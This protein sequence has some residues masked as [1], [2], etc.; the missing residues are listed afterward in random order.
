M[1]GRKSRKSRRAVTEANEVAKHASMLTGTAKTQLLA[2]TSVPLPKRRYG[3]AKQRK[4]SMLQRTAAH[5]CNYW[6]QTAPTFRIPGVKIEQ[7]AER[8]KP[9]KADKSHATKVMDEMADWESDA[10]SAKKRRQTNAVKLAFDGIPP[11]IAE[12]ALYASQVLHHFLRPHKSKKDGRH[13]FADFLMRYK[14]EGEVEADEDKGKDLD[15]RDKDEDEDQ[16]DEDQDQGADEDWEDAPTKFSHAGLEYE[17]A[18]E[19]ENSECTGV[20]HL[21]H[22]WQ[23]QGHH[24]KAQMELTAPKVEESPLKPSADMFRNAQVAL[25]VRWYMKRTSKL[26]LA[27]K[28]MFKVAYP[29]EF[30]IYEKAF[31]AGVWEVADP[32]PWL[33]RAIVWKLNVLPHRDGLDGGPTAIFCLGHFSGGEAYLTDLKLKLWYRPGDVLIF[34]AGDLYHAVGPWKAEGGVTARGITPGRVGNVFFSPAHSLRALK[35]K[36][37][38]WMKS[39]AGGALPSSES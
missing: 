10:F 13:D 16:D 12:D 11:D 34:R 8:S 24:G 22:S 19:Y 39:T 2:A 20:S 28:E 38:G 5:I 31:E 25:A 15:L 30:N 4:Q 21:V 23:M 9:S 3:P 6:L 18:N 32:G 7:L 27:L 14:R 1:A 36:S 26:A 33:G 35:G 37:A 29:D 17:F